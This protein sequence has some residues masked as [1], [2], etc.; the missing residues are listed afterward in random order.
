M[1]RFS[2]M[3]I[4]SAIRS[5]TA[6]WRARGVFATRAATASVLISAGGRTTPGA[7]A[8]TR[9]FG[10]MATARLRTRALIAA[11]AAACGTCVG[12][13]CVAATSET[14]RMDPDERASAGAAA[15]ARK[16]AARGPARKTA[17]QSERDTEENGFGI[18]GDAACT[19]A[20]RRGGEEGEEDEEEKREEEK[21]AS[22][23]AWGAP[24]A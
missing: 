24:S 23:S 2:R 21:T 20:S 13:A 18:Q 19:R 15:C 14:K 4:A 10:P 12:H 8:L 17:S 3:A 5:A 1:E 16:N 6:T 7:T 11:F 22:R 9:T